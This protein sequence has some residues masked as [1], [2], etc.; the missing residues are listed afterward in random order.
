MK[1]QKNRIDQPNTHFV[2]RLL[3]TRPVRQVVRVLGLSYNRVRTLALALRVRS[4]AG[5]YRK[6]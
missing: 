2:Q 3:W 4:P 5:G 1:Q 6:R